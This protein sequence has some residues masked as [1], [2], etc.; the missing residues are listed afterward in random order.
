VTDVD[1][2]Y[3]QQH[4]IHLE[5]ARKRR[6]ILHIANNKEV[7]PDKT[8]LLPPEDYVKSMI[9]SFVDSAQDEDVMLAMA[10]SSNLT[11]ASNARPEENVAFLRDLTTEFSTKPSHATAAEDK[12]GELV[13]E[14]RSASRVI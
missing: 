2:F 6:K 7:N 12:D 10:S 14:E 11:D 4:A 9:L 1:E 8:C 13:K 5:N 3:A